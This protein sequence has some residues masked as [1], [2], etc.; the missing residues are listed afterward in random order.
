[1]RMIVLPLASNQFRV[2]SWTNQIPKFVLATGSVAS[3]DAELPCHRLSML[4]ADHS[5]IYDF[6]EIKI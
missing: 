6:P 2:P 3:V 1:M 5:K 4:K